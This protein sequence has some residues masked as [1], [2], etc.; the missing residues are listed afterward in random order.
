MPE[1]KLLLSVHPEH[2][3]KIFNG[4]KKVELRRTC[5][6]ITMGDIV[7][8]YVTSPI[9]YL[10]G[11]FSIKNVVT[12]SLEQ[13]WTKVQFDAGISRKEFE[14]YYTGTLKGVGLFID[15]VWSFP[16]PISLS[17]LKKIWP[18][19]RPPRSFQYLTENKIN[20]EVLKIIL[21]TE[22]SI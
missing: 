6:S 16:E 22:K 15:E 12:D 3:M 13:L 9:K 5:P 21:N 4:T 1:V 2:A 14:L 19:F 8:V 20:A 11:T 7:L 18:E 17:Y 10:F